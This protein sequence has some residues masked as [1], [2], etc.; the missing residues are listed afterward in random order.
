M[1]E[2]L[3]I[4]HGQTDWN[5]QQRFQGQIDTPLNTTG[6][7][8]AQ[9]L[10]ARLAGERHDA[11][12]SSDL[13][14]A[15]ETALPLGAAWQ[16]PAVALA[17]LREQNFGLLEGL[18]VATIQARHPELWQ[19]WLEQDADFAAPGGESQRRFHARVLAALK[20]LAALAA[21]RR[22]AVVTHGGVLDMLWRTAHGLPLS[23]LR[24]CAIP[25]TG[26]NRLRWA[27]GAL[28][29]DSWADDAH[30]NLPETEGALR[31]TALRPVAP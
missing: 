13:L 30:L 5:L 17:G 11:L 6:H 19:R 24:T 26:L 21:G 16:L 10:A 22:V 4:R 8:Q 23:G 15:R 2:L 20:E 7:A 3:F 18:D 9:R 12:F 14:R 28:H 27:G 29:I 31:Q 1:T 25:N